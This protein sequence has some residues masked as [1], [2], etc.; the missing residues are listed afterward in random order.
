MPLL[1]P[2]ND[3]TAA[4]VIRAELYN[5][6]VVGQDPDV[7]HPHLAADVGQYLVPVVS[8]TRK[9]ALGNVSTTV[10]SISMAPSFLG[11]SSALRPA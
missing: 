2:I 4:E 5:H 7:V 3:A 10:P 11:M 1:V 6:P 8:S 9:K